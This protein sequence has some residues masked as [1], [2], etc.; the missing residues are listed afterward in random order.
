MSRREHPTTDSL[1]KRLEAFVDL[2]FAFDMQTRF[3]KLEKINKNKNKIE[4]KNIDFAHNKI[5]TVW[6]RN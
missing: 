4:W 5:F 1:C 3:C 2:I 6:F